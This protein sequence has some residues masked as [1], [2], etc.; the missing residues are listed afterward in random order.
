VPSALPF[1]AGEKGVGKAGKPLHF[2]GSTFHRVIPQVR[3]EGAFC[4]RGLVVRDFRPCMCVLDLVLT[5]GGC[6][7]LLSAQFMCQGGDF[8]A[9]N[10]ARGRQA[11]L[12]SLEECLVGLAAA[13][14]ARQ[15]TR[16]DIVSLVMLSIAGTGGE[17]GRWPAGGMAGSGMVT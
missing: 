11:R 5:H 8:T 15:L 13:G 9:G 1:L 10:G 3:D 2:K 14:F 16:A 17:V 4:T 12:F 6:P 7:R